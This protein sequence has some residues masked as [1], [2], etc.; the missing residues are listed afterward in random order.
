MEEDGSKEYRWETGYEKTWE[1]IQEDKD[2]ML[3]V[4]VQD[5]IQ[6]A[7]RKRLAARQGKSKL[8]MMRHLYLILDL[9]ESMNSQDF[10]PTR[11]RCSL[12]LL[13]DWIEEYFYL[14]PISQLG[15][16]TTSNKRAERVSELTGNPRRHREVVR[17]LA[18]RQPAGEPSL[19]NS[20]ELALQSLRN[21]PNHASREAILLVGSLTTCDPADIDTT[22][23]TAR[24]NRVRCSVINLAAEVRIYRELA[25]QTGGLH[26]V[27]L[28]DLHA[29]DL[30]A[31]HLDPPAAAAAAESGASL[32][33]MG[34]PSHA[35]RGEGGGLGL[36]LCHLDTA[37]CT[38]ARI[39]T[40]GYLCPQCSAKYC[41]LPVECRGCGLTL[42]SAPHL[43]R[44]YHHLFPLPPF[45]VTLILFPGFIVLLWQELGAGDVRDGA[46]CSGCGRLLATDGG[47][48]GRGGGGAVRC[49]T[50]SALF[51]PECDLFTHE[52]LHSCP[53]CAARPAHQTTPTT[54][55]GS[56]N[57]ASAGHGPASFNGVG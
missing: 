55:G 53:G 38:T 5:I 21:L 48:G 37:D 42:V 47:G 46:V 25:Q 18:S 52:T 1:A 40:A 19:Q 45:Q 24:D 36:C 32:I 30:L 44:S 15:I 39:S 6:K 49:P 29:R 43:A 51:C 12:K 54:N 26:S 7:R 50:C 16:I 28:D 9:S 27:A 57:G 11:L 34:F 4:S 41:E 33:R 22:I 56:N 23:R 13:E 17:G 2:G 3:E 20:L 8:G 14:N 10:K 35:G 31:Q